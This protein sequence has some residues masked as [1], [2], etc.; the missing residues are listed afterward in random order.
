LQVPVFLSIVPSDVLGAFNC[1]FVSAHPFY[2]FCRVSFTRTIVGCFSLHHFS[3]RVQKYRH[4]LRHRVCFFMSIFCTLGSEVAG[5]R[6]IS[7]FGVKFI[8]APFARSASEPTLLLTT[9]VA[10]Q[11]IC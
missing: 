1:D 7:I 3:R 9:F 2:F 5:R 4:P 8:A 10:E 6:E 11:N